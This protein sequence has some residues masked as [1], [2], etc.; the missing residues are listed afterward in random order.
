[1]EN[2][3]CYGEKRSRHGS[4]ECVWEWILSREVNGGLTEK[5][6]EHFNED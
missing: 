6:M 5:R 4:W 3:K 2:T 1:M